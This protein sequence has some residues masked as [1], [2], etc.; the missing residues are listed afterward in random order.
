MWNRAHYFR[1]TQSYSW[2]W[3]VIGPIYTGDGSSVWDELGQRTV[4]RLIIRL[5]INSASRRIIRLDEV[6]TIVRLTRR[7]IAIAREDGKINTGKQTDHPSSRRSN[8]DS[9]SC[10]KNHRGSLVKTDDPSTCPYWCSDRLSANYR[11]LSKLVLDGWF[12]FSVNHTQGLKVYPRF[13]YQI[14]AKN[15]YFTQ[16]FSLCIL[17]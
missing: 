1:E 3:M 2:M 7:T 9:P 5:C 6:S 8:R 15:Q 11:S 10:E 12:V 13:P 4:A 17:I 14:H 16:W